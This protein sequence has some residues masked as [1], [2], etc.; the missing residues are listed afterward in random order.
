MERPQCGF[1]GAD[2]ITVADDIRRI[3][4]FEGA[5]YNLVDF[6]TQG[7]GLPDAGSR[8]VVIR[9][10]LLLRAT[11][12]GADQEA[13]KIP[14]R[15]ET[16][17]SAVSCSGT[18]S[19][20]PDGLAGIGGKEHRDRRQTHHIKLPFPAVCAAVDPATGLLSRLN[21]VNTARTV[22]PI[23][24]HWSLLLRYPSAYQRRYRSIW[25]LGSKHCR[26]RDSLPGTAPSR[27]RRSTPRA[28]DWKVRNDNGRHRF[29]RFYP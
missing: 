9:E 4:A 23:S 10:N 1:K 28:E 7:F 22:L 24:K 8:R 12:K 26:Q 27:C 21:R 11:L 3:P 29:E 13:A 2:H 15:V 17:K 14:T 25:S 20:H 16:G 18:L 6:R 19:T 5:A